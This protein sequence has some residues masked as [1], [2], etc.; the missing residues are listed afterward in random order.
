MLPLLASMSSTEFRRMRKVF[1]SPFFTT[2]ERHLVLYELL[3]K[4]HPI[5]DT[6]KLKKERVFEKL[7]PGKP[8]NDGLLRVMIREFTQMT[9]EYLLLSKLR[10]EDFQRKKIL[11]QVYK[12]RNLYGFFAKETKN[13]LKE[14]DSQPYRDWEYYRE[15]Y[16]LN[17][18]YFF[19]PHTPRLSDGDERLVEIMES[20]DRQYTLAKF[21]IGSEMH[22]WKGSFSKHFDIQ[23]FEE[24]KTLN[25]KFYKNDHVIFRLFDLL[26][27]FYESSEKDLIFEELKS[28]FTDNFGKLRQVNQSLFLTRLINFAVKKINAGESAFYKEALDLY[29]IG[30]ETDLVL[31]DGSI[32]EAVYGNIALLGCHAKEFEWVDNFMSEYKG[33]LKK[34]VRQ[35]AYE[36]NRGLWFFHQNDFDNARDQFMNYAFSQKFQPKARA[37][38]LITLYEQFIKDFSLFD[39]LISHMSSFEKYLHRNA[40]MG[41]AQKEPYFNFISALKKLSSGIFQNKKTQKLKYSLEKQIA[42]KPK[43]IGKSWFLKKI[44]YLK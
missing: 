2:N 23:L 39:L 6:P 37:N 22:N 27:Q 17:F 38:L 18:D 30:L 20:L 8:F 31:R 4:Y 19:H 32:D 15:V 36:L 29:K 11:S 35:D 14:L 43:M 21:R 24:I 44:E 34:E 42:H 3:R 7:Y 12:D 26:F 41:D 13:L 28:V 1:Q 10:N 40:L 5:F 9:E 25:E 33:Y 16:E